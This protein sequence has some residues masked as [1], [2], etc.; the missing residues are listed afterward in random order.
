MPETQTSVAYAGLRCPACRYDLSGLRE[1]ICPECGEPFDA[2]VLRNPRRSRHWFLV[3]FILFIEIYAP[4]AWL[5]FVHDDSGYK[6]SWMY[7]WPALPGIPLAMFISAKIIPVNG[8][9]SLTAI[10]TILTLTMMAAFIWL[11]TRGV[12]WLIVTALIGGGL[13]ALNGWLAYLIFA[14]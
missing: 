13:F 5:F 7:R 10:I 11:A 2:D 6:L 8:D 14:A 12:R 3:I 9:V 1:P 4:F